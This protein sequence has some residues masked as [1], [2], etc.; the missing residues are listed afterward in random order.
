MSYSYILLRNMVNYKIDN[1]EINKDEIGN[2]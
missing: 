1:D 2:S